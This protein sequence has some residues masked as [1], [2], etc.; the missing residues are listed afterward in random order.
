MRQ[1]KAK[2][3]EMRGRHFPEV[4]VFLKHRDSGK[5]PVMNA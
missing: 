3:I 5:K 1:E 4:L 2:V